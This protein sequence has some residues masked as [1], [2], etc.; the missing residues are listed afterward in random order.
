MPI[1][2]RL[3]VTGHGPGGDAIFVEDRRPEPV[4]V[5]ALPGADFHLLWGTPDGG[6]KVGERDAKPVLRPYFPGLGGS[7]ALS[8]G[9]RPTR[10]SRSRRRIPPASPMRSRRSCPG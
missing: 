1:E 10:P 9:G 2:P 4:N 6:A 8:C 3:I 5:Q 7:R